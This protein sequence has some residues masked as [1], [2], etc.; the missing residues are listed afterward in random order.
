MTR[1]GGL[2]WGSGDVRG[3]ASRRVE[4]GGRQQFDSPSYGVGFRSVLIAVLVMVA[5]IVGAIVIFT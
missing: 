5:L 4:R 1:G 2:G 3:E